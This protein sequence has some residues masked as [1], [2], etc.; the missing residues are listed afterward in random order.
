VI[1]KKI[2]IVLSGMLFCS[3]AIASTGFYVG[4]DGGANITGWRGKD[5]V[6]KRIS[7]ASHGIIGD[8]FAGVGVGEGTYYVGLET[9]F[10]DASNKSTYRNLNGGATER[11]VSRTYGYGISLLPGLNLSGSLLYLRLGYVKTRYQI[12][13]VF[14]NANR[15]RP[16][17][18]G[19]QVGVG[20]QSA[21]SENTDIRGEY[22]FSTYHSYNNINGSFTPRETKLVIAVIYKFC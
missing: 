5:N 19:A 20:M 9:F 12:N 8:V 16:F 13:D 17:I 10:N 4:A 22:V 11:R 14:L 1:L 6:G 15:T 7:F 2:F 21:L 3:Q 18:V